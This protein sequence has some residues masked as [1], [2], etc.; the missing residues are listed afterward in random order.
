MPKRKFNPP[1]RIS[2]LD[3]Y[4]QLEEVLRNFADGKLSFVVILGKPGLSKGE[5][6]KKALQGKAARIIKGDHSHPNLYCTLYEYQDKPIVFDDTDKLM[7]QAWFQELLKNLTETNKYKKLEYNKKSPILIETETPVYFHTTSPV[8]LI[9]NWWDT[10]N[11]LCT[12]LESRAEFFVFKPDW[13]ECYK[14][15]ASWFDD[16]EI[17]DYIHDNLEILRQPDAR[18]LVNALTRKKA[19]MTQL[20]WKK[21]IDDHIDDQVGQEV[22]RLLKNKKFASDNA[23]AAKFVELGLG[24]R[25]TFYRRRTDILAFFSVGIPKPARIKLTT[26]AA[27]EEE[28]PMDGP[29]ADGSLKEDKKE[30]E[31]NILTIYDED[32]DDADDADSQDAPRDTGIATVP[33]P[34]VTGTATVPPRYQFVLG[35]KIYEGRP[36]LS[37]SSLKELVAKVSETVG[38]IDSQDVKS[39]QD[40]QNRIDAFNDEFDHESDLKVTKKIVEEEN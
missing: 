33:P 3:K 30:A 37:C 31:D 7:D 13:Y 23:R 38:E 36:P 16:Q 28:R 21:L 40:L 34:K 19:G 12:A 1:A 29:L 15:W 6:T 14:A 18:L 5:S 4:A 24:D 9:M 11:A 10:D 2:S 22:R 39:V 20:T 8:L 35:G 17:Y 25:T 26:Q 27:V 32:V